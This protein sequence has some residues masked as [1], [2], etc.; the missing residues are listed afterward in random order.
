MAII[1]IKNYSVQIDDD[2]AA[3]INPALWECRPSRGKPYFRTVC[4]VGGIRRTAWLHRLAVLCPNNKMVDHKDGDT[5]NNLRINL[6]I[7]DNGQNQQN[8]VKRKDNTSG[9]KGVCFSKRTGKWHAQIHANGK[10]RHLGLFSSARSAALAYNQAAVR[11]Y[12]EFARLNP[13]EA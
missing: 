4:R 7:C 2:L 11:Y 10:R 12:G 5:L 3:D 9:Y 6:R 1:T 13:L 8:R